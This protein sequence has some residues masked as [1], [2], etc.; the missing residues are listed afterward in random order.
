M[1]CC[2]PP[3]P[4]LQA[5]QVPVASAVPARLVEPLAE[6][7]ASSTQTNSHATYGLGRI[8][9]VP[10]RANRDADLDVA[11]DVAVGDVILDHAVE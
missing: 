8:T 7:A 9:H 6:K 5:G 2:A 3:F 10:G 11:L 4:F 1:R